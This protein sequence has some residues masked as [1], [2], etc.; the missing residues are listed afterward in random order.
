MA[1][2]SSL[3]YRSSFELAAAAPAASAVSP[4]SLTYAL[5]PAPCYAAPAAMWA[6]L[7]APAIPALPATAAAAA[8]SAASKSSS[9]ENLRLRAKQHAASLGLHASL[10]D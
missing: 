6:P 3:V 1:A 4:H 5:Q 9:I 2:T 8:A 7:V 10:R